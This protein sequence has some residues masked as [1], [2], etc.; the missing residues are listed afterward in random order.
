MENEKQL[1]RFLYCFLLK[2]ISSVAFLTLE[3]I[4][5]CSLK[6]VVFFCRVLDIIFMANISENQPSFYWNAYKNEKEKTIVTISLLC[7]TWK[8]CKCHVLDLGIGIYMNTF[9]SRGVIL[10]HFVTS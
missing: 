1:L 4:F 2:R 6:Q 9:S 3:L 7:F 10:N 5:I 8:D